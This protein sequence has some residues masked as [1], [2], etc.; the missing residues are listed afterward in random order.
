MAAAVGNTGR[1]HSDYPGRKATWPDVGVL[2]VV[3]GALSVL[4]FVAQYTVLDKLRVLPP[5]KPYGTAPEY[6]EAVSSTVA[7]GSL[8]FTVGAVIT[9]LCLAIIVMEVR[10]LSLSRLLGQ[11]LRVEWRATCATALIA[12]VCGRFYLARGPLHQTGDAAWHVPYVLLTCQSFAEGQWP[13]WTNHF[14]CGTPFLQ[15]YGSLFFHL[16]GLTSL[17]VRDGYLATKLVMMAG[18][19]ISGIGMYSLIRV[20][21]RSRGAGMVAALA[22]TLSFWHTQQVIILGRFPLSLFY[23][24]LPWPFYFFEK[25]RLWNKGPACILGGG[26]CLGGLAHVHP[27]YAFWATAL[28]VAYVCVRALGA[29]STA[30]RGVRALRVGGLIALLGIAFGASVTVPMLVERAATGLAA[31]VDLS[32]LP[33][34]TWQQLLVWSNY[35]FRLWEEA[36]QPGHWYGGYL[37]VTIGVAALAAVL[38]YAALKHRTARAADVA[39]AVGLAATLLL[40]FGYRLPFLQTL[41]PVRALNAGR[42]LLFVVF[43]MAA[44]A[45]MAIPVVTT[46]SRDRTGG[47]RVAAW[48]LILIATDLGPTTVRHPY[49]AA[50]WEERTLPEVVDAVSGDLA[51]L[52]EGELPGYR[53]YHYQGRENQL[54]GLSDVHRVTGIPVCRA[55]YDESTTAMSRFST[56]FARL[57]SVLIE[58]SPDFVE[59]SFSER[60]E[61]KLVTDGL[62]LLNVK[63]MILPTGEGDQHVLA[64]SATRSPIVVA[65]R[66]ISVGEDEHSSRATRV[67]ERVLS[68]TGSTPDER[69]LGDL[70]QLSRVS[71]AIRGLE[72]DRRGA[73]AQQ[74]LIE[75]PVED[76]VLGTSPQV[77]VLQHHVWN[78][79][80]ELTVQA[81]EDCFA[82][83]A[84]AHYPH[85]RVRVDGEAVEPMATIGGFI[86]LRLG[87]GQHII[88]LTP[89][90][91]PLRKVLLLADVVL[92]LAAVAV[93]YRGRRCRA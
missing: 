55:F 57:A 7:F 50:G 63:Y 91:S 39:L 82:R 78:Q 20:V 89:E 35:Q 48:F 85:L 38:G 49:V 87:A 92:L 79:A 64:K 75:G 52:D 22:Y 12:F 26:L 53:L 84:Y 9:A 11:I 34:P 13:I 3:L 72:L 51:G 59:G 68:E 4:L 71:L 69:R 65:P 41:A 5:S 80:V 24:L 47:M 14:G 70:E 27:G 54:Y 77:K 6:F 28:Y 40:V 33:D 73:T 31:G 18:H 58:E 81:S 10:W 88:T 44:L 37:G 29:R 66:I 83:L 17:L 1:P 60:T 32:A 61:L 23:G 46:L 16:A 62:Y 86:A 30:R 74:L 76:Q 19:V 67:S 43:Y 93:V 56:P 45:G 8:D 90:L 15:F 2:R 36:V 25:S 42:Y 21:T